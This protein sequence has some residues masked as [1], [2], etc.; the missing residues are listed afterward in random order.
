VGQEI[1][2][3]VCCAISAGLKNINSSLDIIRE[4]YNIDLA[5][6]IDDLN[7]EDKSGTFKNDRR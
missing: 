4:C 1:C 5:I 3:F 7:A 2:L 6:K